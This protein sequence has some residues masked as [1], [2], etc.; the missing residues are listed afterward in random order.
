MITRHQYMAYLEKDYAQ[1]TSS[2]KKLQDVLEKDRDILASFI[3]KKTCM[4]VALYRYKNMLFLYYEVV[5]GTCAPHEFFPDLTE[6]LTSVPLKDT[7][8]K[9][10]P[11][12]HIYHNAVP[13][14]IKNWQRP[15]KKQ[16]IGRI[17]YLLPDKMMSYLYYHK[18]LLEEG[19]FEGERYLS[20]GLNDTVL[21][22]Y[23]ESPRLL[24]H[25]NLESDEESTVITKWR[26]Q[27]PKSH[28]DHTFSG[29]GNFVD[30]EELLSLGW[31][32]I[33]DEKYI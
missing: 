7:H 33:F 31:E 15:N 27:N 29:E 25:L 5:D 1:K 12:H 17:A 32:E 26:E 2:E 9:W 16:R 10:I 11:M 21:F 8:V 24:T 13:D 4:T 22:V 14:T 23:S 6:C 19:L 30:L 28:F 20:I 18:E 3:Q